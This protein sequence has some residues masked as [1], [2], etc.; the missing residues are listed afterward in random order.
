MSYVVYHLDSLQAVRQYKTRS[1]AQGLVDKLNVG[2]GY[3]AYY[4]A[5][6]LRF[7]QAV[8]KARQEELA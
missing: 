7:D 8:E 2:E 5:D 4:Y 1:R 3:L 6:D